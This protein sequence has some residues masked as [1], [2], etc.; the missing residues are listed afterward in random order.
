MYSD[1]AFGTN[2]HLTRP[3]HNIYKPDMPI[4]ESRFTGQ[5]VTETGYTPQR[6][7]DDQAEAFA[8]APKD[9]FKE[10]SIPDGIHTP[11]NE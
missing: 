1:M 2:P 11:D 10:K 5:E 8:F 3:F 6:Y 4:S 9:V 7:I